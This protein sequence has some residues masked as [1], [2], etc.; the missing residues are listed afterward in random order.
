MSLSC[1]A[2]IGT[3]SAARDVVVFEGAPAIVKWR[4]VDSRPVPRAFGVSSSFAGD[5]AHGL[6][7]PNKEIPSKYLYDAEGSRL[8]DLI[9]ELE[10]YYVTRAEIQLLN[11]NAQTIAR[12]IGS[13][14]LLIEYGSGSG[15]KTQLLLEHLVTPAA[16]VPVDISTAYLENSAKLLAGRFPELRIVPLCADFTAHIALPPLDRQPSRRVV[17]F[18]G[19]TIGNLDALEAT[20]LLRRTLRLC[21]TNGGLLLGI[22]L[23]KDV[24]IIERAYND[25]RG[26]TRDFNRNLL[27][28]MNR[29]LAA[30]FCL[31]SFEHHAPYNRELNCI[32]MFLV[33][34]K[35][36]EV[37]VG[38]KAY[39]FDAGERIRTE[40]SYKYDLTHVTTWLSA[41]G[42]TLEQV[43]SDDQHYIAVLYLSVPAV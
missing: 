20:A 1:R 14:A 9:C 32:E 25:S 34:E 36:Q 26:V 33:S 19:T 7:R 38:G 22:D 27:V 43:W 6:S 40:R 30:N 4:M 18:P 12:A 35:E 24:S 23:Q 21:G 2:A 11:R 8:F 5:I 41:V 37:E 31:E 10:E 29:E 13:D 17:F 42:F 3:G 28:R 15:K 39:Q 16:Y